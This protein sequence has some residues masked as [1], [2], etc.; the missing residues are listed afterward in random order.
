MIESDELVPPSDPSTAL[1]QL[2]DRF[3]MNIGSTV[4]AFRQ[5]A[6]QLHRAPAAPEVLDALSRELHRIRGT[7]GSYGFLE[8]GRLA[9][10]LDQV[11]VRWVADIT[12]DLPRRSVV[13]RQF[14][15]ILAA[16]FDEGATEAVDELSAPILLVDVPDREAT[17]LIAEALVR[18]HFV[19]RLPATVAQQSIDARPPGAVIAAARV[20][21]TVPAES[22]HVLLRD[23]D[24]TVVPH[25][26]NGQVVELGTPPAQVLQLVETRSARAS[27][28]GATVLV[29]DDEGGTLAIVQRVTTREGM[30]VVSRPW[31]ADPIAVLQELRPVL[32][33]IPWRARAASTPAPTG[34]RR[35]LG[36]GLGEPLGRDTVATLRR[37]RADRRFAELPLLVLGPQVDRDT[38]TAL[39][40]AGADDLQSTPVVEV[41]LARRVARLIE[42]RRQR[43]TARSIHPATALTLPERTHRD[44]DEVLREATVL[45]RATSLAILRPLEPPD[46]R[47]RTTQWQRECAMVAGALTLDGGRSG[48]L[49]DTALGILLPMGAEDAMARLTPFAEFASDQ[50]GA[51][52]A[53]VVEQLPGAEAVLPELIRAAEEAWL[54]ARDH[55][56]LVRRW[57]PSDVTVAPDVILVEDDTALAELVMYALSA[58]G[59]THRRFEDGPT[60]LAELVRL[61]CYHRHPILIVDV[62]LPGLDGFSLF[63]RL[64]VERPGVYKVVF[65]SVRGSEA[66]QLRALRAGALD[67]LPKPVSLR[68]LLAKISVWRN[69]DLPR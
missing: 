22:V 59:L 51:W 63:D 62:D 45:G 48:F 37:I 54:V 46:G 32:V 5:L 13:V 25:G 40:E 56:A 49:D 3:L 43:L 55:G 60:A 31:D 44:F 6:D 41:E 61:R 23:I 19:E 28:A 47:Q 52:A 26:A 39:F 35:P 58:R 42:V 21:L 69:Q 8:V 14:A 57:D 68:V 7:A 30:Q 65:M 53:G 66:D 34:R 1:D 10:A 38:R 24:G 29:L 17:G 2:R 20:P 27:G 15:R 36:G 9:A 64:R 11:V 67:Y 12:L 18:G 50:L 33:V 4:E 16:A